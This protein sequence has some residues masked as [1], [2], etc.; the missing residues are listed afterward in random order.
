MTVKLYR[1][2]GA[3]RDELLGVKS[4][5]IDFSV[6]ASSYDEMRQY[7]I[8][9]G[10]EIFLETPEFVTIRARFGRE[11]ADY[12]L[13]RKD[14]SY[15]DGRRPDNVTVGTLFDDLARRDFTMNAIAK[16][17]N[18][19][20]I[21][22]FNGRQDIER[23]I[24][25]CVGNAYDRMNE[26]V[27]RLLRAMRFSIT[28][29]MLIDREICNLFWDEE[30]IDKFINTLPAD[31]IRDEL[32]KMFAFDTMNTIRMFNEYPFMLNACF[33]KSGIWLKPTSEKV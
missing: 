28:K 1:V 8:D 31:R 29:K 16:D 27:L 22:P 32:T 2:G 12:V 23:G 5:D 14:G 9:T 25:R 13:C 33:V 11:T 4:K 3:V 18:G 7:I 21:D 30:L 26:D 10:G 24:I 15:S 20:Y 17:E 6:E 19:N